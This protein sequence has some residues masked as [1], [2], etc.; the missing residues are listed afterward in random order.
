MGR[1]LFVLILFTFFTRAFSQ[2]PNGSTAPDF[3]VQDINGNTYSLYAMMGANKAACLDF[4]ATWCSPCWAFHQSGT[5]EEVATNLSS[6]ATVLFLEGDWST[7]TACLYDLPSCVGGT[8][9]DWVTGTSYP[10]ADLSSTNGSAL[11]AL[12]KV[13]YYPTLYIV[14][15]D[16]RI[17]EVEERTYQSYVNWITESFTLNATSSI[18]HSTCGDNGKIIMNTTGGYSTIDYKW[19]NGATTKDLNNIPGGSYSVTIT[20]AN[21][22]FLKYGPYVINGPSKR[23][24]VSASTVTDIKCFN[25]ATGSISIQTSF[26]TPPYSYNWSTNATTKN[27][28]GLKAGYYVLTITDNNNCTRVRSYTLTQPID[29]IA[30]SSS[31]KDNCN[32]RDGFIQVKAAGGNSPYS[33]NIG[34]GEQPGPYFPD[35]KGGKFYTVTITDENDCKETITTYVDL[36]NKPN[37]DAGHDKDLDCIK[38]IIMLDGSQSDQ[39]SSLNTI[40]TTKD[41]NI[42]KGGESLFPEIDKPGKYNLKITDSGNKCFDIDSVIVNDARVFPNIAAAGDTSL[43][44]YLTEKEVKGNSMHL[45]IKYYW[46]KS[47]DSLFYDTSKNIIVRDSGKYIF[48][49]KDTINLCISRDTVEIKTDQTKPEAVASPEKEVSCKNTEIIIDGTASSQGAKYSYQWSTINGSIV[50]GATTLIPIV[51]KGGD[52]TLNVKNNLNYCAKT[53][54]VKVLEQTQPSSGFDQSIN[55]LNV[56]FNDLSQGL[57]TSWNWTFGDGGT[58]TQKNPAHVFAADG[59]YTVCLT[60]DNDCGQDIKCQKIN[61][62]VLALTLTCPV[63]STETAC[64]TQAA[65]NAKFVAWLNTASFTGGCDPSLSNDNSGSPSAC[66]GTTMVT[67]AVTS[68]CDPTVTCSAKFTVTNSPVV[69]LTCPSHDFETSCQTQALIDTKFAAWLATATFTGGCNAAISNNN[70]GAPSAC[71]GTTTVTFIVTSS[72]SPP[73][74]CS[75][76]F[77]VSS[78]SPVSISCP[79]NINESACKTQIVIDNEYSSRLNSVFVTGGCNAA[80]SNNS[81]GAPSACGGSKTVTFTVTSTCEPNKTCKSIFSVANAPPITLTCPANQTEGLGQ[82]QT[83]I[84]QKFTDWLSSASYTDG[85]DAAISNNNTGAPPNTGSYAEVNFTVTNTCEAPVI[86]TATFTVKDITATRNPSIV[87][88]FELT[89]NPVNGNGFINIQLDKRRSFKL[90]MLNIYGEVVWSNTSANT[91]ESIPIDL[92]DFC[93]GLYFVVLNTNDIQQVLKWMVD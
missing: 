59:E 28:A 17:W 75:A 39:G 51:N 58:S 44:C 87:K 57:P 61:V 16:K 46:K 5:L 76:T 37:A 53:A 81:T 78:S 90:S 14:S 66:G 31:G 19:N 27:I 54:D 1:A 40:W 10:I 89:P 33:F 34:V 45:P 6:Q 22:Y 52:Y 83:V 30:T 29:L 93:S 13:A 80:L 38:E 73:K 50:S 91:S 12:Y 15:P 71:G 2:L 47:N 69:V 63:N 24:D 25:E 86:C 18:T 77:G 21:G 62:G 42:V 65:I 43:N 26:G 88:R 64:Q 36:T 8:Q 60:I 3:S 72:C 56:Q 55:G 35:L 11:K 70:S 23:V 74:T 20:D 84:N 9:G 4:S 92:N 85:C 32:N 7:N 49:V 79:P 41:G 82:T 67:F 68:S 48:H